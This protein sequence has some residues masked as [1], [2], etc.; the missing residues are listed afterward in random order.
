M[1]FFMQCIA[2]HLHVINGRAKLSTWARALASRSQAMER[3]LTAQSSAKSCS[4]SLSS[5]AGCQSLTHLFADH[6]RPIHYFYDVTPHKAAP[7]ELPDLRW[8]HCCRCYYPH[9]L[10]LVDGEARQSVR[11]ICARFSLCAA[12]YLHKGENLISIV[13]NHDACIITESTLVDSQPSIHCT[14]LSGL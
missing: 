2:V 7:P 9:A 8:D 3:E 13:F 12:A 1:N 14:L 11:W 5:G 6:P 4:A 10:E